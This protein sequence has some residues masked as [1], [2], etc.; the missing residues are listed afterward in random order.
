MLQKL[1]N[2]TDVNDEGVDHSS[3]NF[4][5]YTL[6]LEESRKY[7][8]NIVVIVPELLSSPFLRK[9]KITHKKKKKSFLQK[10]CREIQVFHLILKALCRILG[11]MTFTIFL[12]QT[13]G[14]P[15]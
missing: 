2:K 12:L 5:P 1:Q 8:E 9:R 11:Y 14:A 6:S 13:S 4:K 15:L 7:C 10:Q 3:V